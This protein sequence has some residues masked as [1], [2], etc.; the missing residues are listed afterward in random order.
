MCDKMGI[1][2]IAEGIENKQQL[3]VLKEYGVKTVQ[4]YLFSKPISLS[5]YKEK[6]MHP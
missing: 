2:L 1:Q 6:Y 5:E 3:D 4:G